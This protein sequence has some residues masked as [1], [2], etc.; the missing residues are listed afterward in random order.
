[1]KNCLMDRNSN[2]SSA[3]FLF[4]HNKSPPKMNTSKNRRKGKASITTWKAQ[5]ENE[6]EELQK[7][8]HT[9]SQNT[10]VRGLMN[11]KRQDLRSVVIEDDSVNTENDIVSGSNSQH[12]CTPKQKPY[13]SFIECAHR[14]RTHDSSEITSTLKNYKDDGSVDMSEHFVSTNT[15]EKPLEKSQRNIIPVFASKLKAGKFTGSTTSKP[16]QQKVG[17]QN[18]KINTPLGE[19]KR[20]NMFSTAKLIHF[21][22]S[23]SE[24]VFPFQHSETAQEVSTDLHSLAKLSMENTKNPVNNLPKTKNKQSVSVAIEESKSREFIIFHQF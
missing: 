7:K 12:G 2:K 22:M 8:L 17:L 14:R 10:K 19:N 18:Y 21:N 11:L 20:N 4:T 16:S 23:E 3:K 24:K 1:M 6:I 15:K 5:K 13:T 9:V